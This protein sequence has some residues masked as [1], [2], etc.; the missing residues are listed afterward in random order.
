MHK[1]VLASLLVVAALLGFQDPC[2]FAAGE[3][4]AGGAR[5]DVPDGI[6]PWRGG[7]LV[8]NGRMYGVAALG[9]VLTREWKSDVAGPAPLSQI[10]WVVGPQYGNAN[11]GFGWEILPEIGGRPEA[12]THES[13]LSPT[14]DVPFWGSSAETSQ[15]RLELRDVIHPEETVWLRRV[16]LTTNPTGSRVPLALRIPVSAD[17]RNAAKDDPAWGEKERLGHVE[18]KAMLQVNAA[19]ETILLQGARRR[20]YTEWT[21]Q[22]MSQVMDHPARFLATAVTVEG[23]DAKVAVDGSG[24]RVEL[25][26]VEPVQQRVINIWLAAGESEAETRQLLSARQRRGGAKMVADSKQRAPEPL[27]SRIDGQ[28]DPIL[29][30]IQG[31]GAVCDAA[32]AHCGGVLASP[33]MYPM[34]YV[35]DQFGS[36]RLFLEQGAYQRA[37]HALAYHVAMQNQWGIQNSYEAVPDPPDPNQWS[38]THPS[39][40]GQGHAGAEVPAYIILMARDYYLATGDLARVAPLYARLAYNLRV[41]KF[42]PETHLLASPTDESYTQI[43]GIGGQENFTDS[44]ILFLGAVD[45]MVRLARELGHHADA[46]EFQAL[47]D[48]TFAAMKEHLWEKEKRYFT[49]CK[50]DRRPCFDPLLRWFHLGIGDRFDPIQQGCLDAVLGSLI[51]PIRVVPDRPEAAGMEPGYLLQALSRAQRS[52]MHDAARLLTRYASDTHNMNEFYHHG[53]DAMSGKLR[54]WESGVAGWALTQYLLGAQPDLPKEKLRLQPHLPPGWPGWTS[55]TIEL[56]GQGTM[57]YRLEQQAD[58]SIAFTITR[59]SGRAPLAVEVEFGGF[60]D[61]LA[62]LS[63]GLAAVAGR[64]DLLEGSFTL[65]PAGRRR[66][67][68]VTLRFVAR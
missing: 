27:F 47:H 56:P 13:I 10:A 67:N 59:R 48:R 60:G 62:P 11:L 21:S 43:V 42:N 68:S 35:R 46:A 40:P 31:C 17:P 19:E 29:E 12:W 53:P 28:S 6:T 37:W 8:G 23:G 16:V 57:K 14:P 36:F 50:Q 26:E 61:A 1:T 45:F 33:Y 30:M 38:Q 54:P 32:Q 58:G 25:G 66:E 64:A 51:N 18:A 2:A 34:C 49:I 15:V 20:L 4:P 3:E 63:P 39:E 22:P 24:F 65:A 55:R 52:Q 44:N 7:Y 41:H 5:I 9:A